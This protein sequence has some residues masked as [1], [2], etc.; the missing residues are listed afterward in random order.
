MFTAVTDGLK[1]AWPQKGSAC[2][3]QAII[4]YE[5]TVLLVE[6]E[7]DGKLAHYGKYAH[8]SH[9]FFNER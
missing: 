3:V 5:L 9:R 7:D 8:S 4:D 1:D 2:L 6:I